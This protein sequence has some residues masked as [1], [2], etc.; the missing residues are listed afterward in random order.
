MH[1]PNDRYV[2]R[3]HALGKF[4][5]LVTATAK[6]RAMLFYLDNWLSADPA[7]F[8]RMRQEMEM[9]RQRF[10]ARFG[11]NDPFGM[12]RFP[13]GRGPG[14]PGKQNQ[15]QNRGLNEDYSRA[16]MEAHTLAGDGGHR[17]GGGI[18]QAK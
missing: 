13:P 5:D 18:Q 11:G 17:Q 12:R 3:P 10:N 15:N 16:H 4:K 14:P 2:S 1:E 7:S 6:S 9:R 8:A